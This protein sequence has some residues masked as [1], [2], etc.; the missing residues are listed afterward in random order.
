LKF[1]T[2]LY[3]RPNGTPQY[4][5]KGC[6]ERAY[7]SGGRKISVPPKARIVLQYWESE[8]KAFAMERF[9]IKLFGRKDNKTGILR[10]LT[11]GGEGASVGNQIRKGMPAPNILDMSGQKFGRLTVLARNP[12]NT[13]DRKTNWICRCDCGKEKITSGKLLRNGHTRSCGCLRSD[14]MHEIASRPGGVLARR[15]A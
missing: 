9:Y 13:S 12:K 3:L 1:Y 11:N 2:Y 6:G 14:L 15:R 4:V 8:E 10:N 7:F 5:G